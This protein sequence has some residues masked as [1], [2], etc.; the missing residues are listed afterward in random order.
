MVVCLCEGFFGWLGGGKGFFWLGAD[1]WSV[2]R[3]RGRS[4]AHKKPTEEDVGMYVN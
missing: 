4:K 2:V 1:E 3:G